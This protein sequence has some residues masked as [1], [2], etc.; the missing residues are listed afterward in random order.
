[1]IEDLE[2]GPSRT[3]YIRLNLTPV[4]GLNDK[5]DDSWS[6]AEDGPMAFSLIPSSQINVL[7]RCWS[8][9]QFGF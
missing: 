2:I 1:M 5:F 3:R 9:N 4:A 6:L 7:A 8:A